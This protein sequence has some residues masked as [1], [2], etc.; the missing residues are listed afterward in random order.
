MTRI[1]TK[2]FFTIHNINCTKE[3]I[4]KYNNGWTLEEI[5]KWTEFIKE[6]FEKEKKAFNET[7]K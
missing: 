1:K 5:K 3:V 6:N 2:T 4:D 7:R